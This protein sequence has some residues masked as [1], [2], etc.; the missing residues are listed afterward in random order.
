[1]SYP[2]MVGLVTCCRMLAEVH[3]ILYVLV[4]GFVFFS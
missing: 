3:A 1:V 4:E 2:I